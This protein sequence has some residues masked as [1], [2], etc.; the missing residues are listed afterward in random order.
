MSIRVLVVEDDLIQQQVLERFLTSHGYHVATAG[1]GLEAV[2]KIRDNRFDVIILDYAM[3][4]F[5]GVAAARWI[6][7]EITGFIRPCLIALSANTQDM[8]ESEP[9][10]D[11]IFDHIEQKP[12]NPRT[13]ISVL[14]THDRSSGSKQIGHSHDAPQTGHVVS[15]SAPVNDLSGEDDTP[16]LQVTSSANKVKVLILDEDDSVLSTFKASLEE[17]NYDVTSANS[18]AEAVDTIGREKFDIVFSDYFGATK[19][20]GN[21][22]AFLLQINRSGR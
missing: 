3:P 13:L 18:V 22:A 21:P 7:R 12:W 2:K 16:L 4:S 5:D 6:R 10:T 9:D 19:F 14:Q 11:K 17:A 1:T 15:E 20:C 8:L